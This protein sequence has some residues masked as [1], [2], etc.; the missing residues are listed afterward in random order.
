VTPA[1]TRTA[2]RARW[3]LARVLSWGLAIVALAFVAWVIPLRDRCWDPRSPQSTRV[4]VSRAAS[5]CV[6]H[7]RS[8][9][10]P[11]D[12]G[13]CAQLRCEPG[14]VPTLAAARLGVLLALLAVYA[15]GTLAWA[16]RWRAL[17]GFA[18]IDIRLGEV[19]RLSIEAQAGG[20]LLPGGIGGDAFRIASVVSRPAAVRPS[21]AIVVASVL[22]DRA[23]GLSLIAA[24]ACALGLAFAGHAVGFDA[25]T[26][27][28][29][30][31]AIPVAVFVGI[32]VLRAAPEAALAKLFGTSRIGR[33]VEQVVSPVLAYVRDP[34]AP[35]AIAWA[36][37][38]SLIVAASQLA[39][40]RGLVTALGATPSL[41]GGG[42][43]WVY[44]GAAMAFIVGAI[45]ALPGGWGTADATYVFFFGLAGL[46]PGVGLSVCLLFRLFWY[47]SGIVG[48]IL[49]LTRSGASAGARAAK[50][51]SKR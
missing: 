8:G 33:A 21:L 26:L 48:A 50:S 42:E 1:E 45:P 4:A 24:V 15:G 51:M 11:I 29:V 40:V 20:I 41:V 16:A 3:R 35:R 12:A 22:L 31:A 36:V 13:E 23:I 34:R 14:V 28:A 27:L 30:L 2:P 6:L 37:A 19:W 9:D 18:G 5:E 47:L 46:A 32:F 39:V 7:L 10:V 44:V 17:L 43:K 49:Y 25:G 38:W